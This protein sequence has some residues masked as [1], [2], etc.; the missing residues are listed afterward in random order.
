[1]TE[2]EMS[3]DNA[4]SRWLR[5]NRVRFWAIILVLAYTLFGFLGLPLLIESQI[6]SQAEQKLGRKATVGEVKVNPYVLSLQID[7][8][9]LL[10]Q[11]DETLLAFD[12]LLVNFQLS[13]LFRWA[14][15]FREVSLDGSYLYFERYALDDTRLSRML[16]DAAA[17][18][19]P[20]PEDAA[21]APALPRLL[22]HELSLNGGSV[23]VRDRLPARP[24]ELEM[25]PVSV[26][27]QELNTL[28]NRYG[29]QSVLIRFP[30]DAKLSWQGNISLAPLESEGELTI[31]N[32]PLDKTIAY[33]EAI[34]PLSDMSAVL[35]ARTRYRLQVRPNGGFGI[36]LQGLEAELEELQVS[37]LEPVTNFFSLPK[38]TVRGGT[39]RYPENELS[40]ESITLSGPRLA[41]WLDESGTPSLSQLNTGQAQAVQPDSPSRT[42]HWD[43][44][45]DNIHI[46]DGRVQLA[47]RSITPAGEVGL[48]G[49]NLTLQG[50]DNREGSRMSAELRGSLDAGGDFSFQG[51]LTALPQ[52]SMNGSTSLEALSLAVGQPWLQQQFN[53]LVREGALN[54]RSDVALEPDGSVKA[55]GDMEI[56][57]LSVQDS[58]E[59]ENL[60]GWRSLAI[61][62]YE[63]QTGSRSLALS[64][65]SLAD[66]Y[67]RI[68]INEDR[69]TNLDSLVVR[70]A[71]ETE[72]EQAEPWSLVVGGIGLNNGTLDFSDL[73]LPLPF[74][75]RISGL[76]GTVSTI[77]TASTEPASIR[78]EGQVDEYGLA[79]IDGTLAVLDPI[80]H[81]DIELEFR[82]LLM[83]RLS[84]YSAQF[85]GQEIDEGKLDLDLGYAIDQGQLKGRNDIVLSDL[86][87]G[88]KVDSPDAVSLPLGLAVALLTDSN[89]VI[90]IDLPIEGDVNDPEF[91]IGGVVVQAIVGLITK[92]VS[93]PFRMLG[94][95]IGVDSEDFGQ[96][97]FLAGRSDLTPPEIEKI[98]QLQEALQQRPELS[99]EVGGVFDEAVDGPRLRF[100]RLRQ[101]V[102]D[103]LGGEATDSDDDFEMLDA[104]IRSVL[105][106]L[107]VERF[108]ESPPETLKA[109]YM[110]APADDP[111]AKPVL[112]ELAYAAELRDRLLAAEEITGED[113]RRLAN[114]RANA[115]REAFL[116]DGGFE[117]ER[118]TVAA[119]VAAESE[120]GEWIVLELGVAAN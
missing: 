105:E 51:Q 55:S 7:D 61:D 35:S 22:I 97:H 81:T 77:D 13:S 106:T 57:G 118:I 104:E 50:V 67:G 26:A 119:P 60:V 92:V 91:K 27:V 82:N 39:M 44:A 109:S 115:I 45:V 33:L 68:E 30:G 47:D 89:G 75:T 66:A 80:G 87:L 112:D 15:T 11:D 32:S 38:L 95:L 120:D 93:A 1:M 52:L 53:L 25:G 36:E 24:V 98:S 4:P 19:P 65:V 99:V 29:Q 8:F 108:P 78:M 6:R 58:V 59:N 46:E 73:S 90:D 20:E 54:S 2:A 9:A 28:P 88:E 43:L 86:V 48:S 49:L 85:A 116:A 96:F 110:A 63:L 62:R 34:L 40:L 18:N 103:R 102:V 3:N 70:S 100:F 117:P 64:S 23:A 37:G 84:P 5:P 41:V 56:V 31:E 42:T 74:A 83:S 12:R 71:D 79:R 21:N 111:E 101:Q 69:T 76:D 113:L 114:E 10:D 14:W 72:T 107:F 16:A 17:N 94:S